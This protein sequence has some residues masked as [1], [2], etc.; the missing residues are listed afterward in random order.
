[1][2][3]LPARTTVSLVPRARGFFRWALSRIRAY[4]RVQAPPAE[5]AEQAAWGFAQ[6][7]LGLRAIVSDV[8]L[9]WEAAYPA[10]VLGLACALYASVSQGAGGWAWFGR[11]YKA[12]ATLAPLPSLIFANHYA[13][14][15]A[16]IRWR[17]G[18]GACGPREMPV[19]MLFGRMIRQ[20]GIV[21]I[22]IAPFAG[23]ISALPGIGPILSNVALALWG[24]H[25]VVADA[26][27]DAQVLMPG[28][29]LKDSV[30]HDRSAPP[31]WFVRWMYIAAEKVPFLGKPLRGFARLCDYLA[32]DSRGEIH[33]MEQNPF[34]SF[35]FALSTAAL[36]ATPVLNLL[37]RPIILAGSSHLLG[38]LEKHEEQE[39]AIS[40]ERILT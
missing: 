12:F 2:S 36:L 34:I 35:G 19:G 6:P 4:S 32:L 27:D 39:T 10:A 8:Q 30:H 14:L 9:L 31:P 28:E 40:A 33:T 1:M 15:G 17:L 21:A 11:F 16:L 7:I 24:V 18:L 22:G 3:L 38:Q 25:W 29:T 20:A 26:F 13:R 23:L 37:F 5:P